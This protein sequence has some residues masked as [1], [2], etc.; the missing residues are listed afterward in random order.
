MKLPAIANPQRW[1]LILVLVGVIFDLAVSAVLAASVVKANNAASA[2]H[3]A[4]IAAY[5]ACV[6]GNQYRAIDL[7][8]WNRVLQLINDNPKDPKLQAFV[9]S[10][11]KANAEAD[12]QRD[13]L[14][15]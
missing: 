10:V 3:Q 13:C 12:R 14:A 6:Y 5:Q 15:P 8:R 9:N 11:A 2:S 1:L 4:R 7:T